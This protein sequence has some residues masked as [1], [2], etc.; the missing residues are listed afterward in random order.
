MIVVNQKLSNEEFMAERAQVLGMAPIGREIDLEEALAY[1]KA[2]PASRSIIQV[3]D[4]A[5]SKGESL[6]EARGGVPIPEEQA[7]LLKYLHEVGKVD[8]LPA[9]ADTYTRTC[10]FQK[11]PPLLQ[12]KINWRSIELRPR[13]PVLKKLTGGEGRIRTSVGGAS[14]FTVC[15][16]WP[17]GYL[18]SFLAKLLPNY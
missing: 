5:V 9:S 11:K 1:R 7:Q 8:I 17:L 2:M 14:R 12:K 3:L 13:L 18:S 16:L 4:Q 10:L 6:T 15:P